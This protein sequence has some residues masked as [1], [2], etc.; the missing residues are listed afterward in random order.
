MCQ[1][2]VQY[3]EVHV[4]RE[5][6]IEKPYRIQFFTPQTPPHPKKVNE[7]PFIFWF[8]GEYIDIKPKVYVK[9]ICCF[10]LTLWSLTYNWLGLKRG[11]A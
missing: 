2:S 9:G 7:A 6:C 8:S 1:F 10:L 5:I 11:V 3:L 4:T